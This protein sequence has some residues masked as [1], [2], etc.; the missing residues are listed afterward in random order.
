MWR[1]YNTAVSISTLYLYLLFLVTVVLC[2]ILHLAS[3]WKKT[4][5]ARIGGHYRGCGLLRSLKVINFIMILVLLVNYSVWNI[6]WGILSELN[7]SEELKKIPTLKAKLKFFCTIFLRFLS[8]SKTLFGGL[9][10]TYQDFSFSKHSSVFIA[11][12]ERFQYF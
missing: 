10:K 2:R 4:T 6:S 9:I 5:R 1:L 8:I 12:F 11:L 3:Q 7:F